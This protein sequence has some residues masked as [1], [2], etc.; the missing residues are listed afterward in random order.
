NFLEVKS[1]KLPLLE[2]QCPTEQHR[3]RYHFTPKRN[4]INDPNGM[5]YYDG[6]YHLFY[7]YHPYS[8]DRGPMHWGHATS[9]DMLRWEEQDVAL[10][11]DEVG[12]C[13]SG[14]SVIDSTNTTGFQTDPNVHPLVAIYTSAGEAGQSQSIAYSNDKGATFTKYPGN[15][16]IPNPDIQDFRDPKVSYIRGQWVMTLAVGNRIEFYG[17]PDLKTWTKLSEFG[18][19]PEEGSHC[20]SWECPDLFPLIVDVNGD[21]TSLVELWV[22]LVSIGCGGPTGG[23]GTQYFVGDFNGTTFTTLGTWDNKQ[24]LDWGPDNYAAVSFSNEPNGRTIL[25]GWM[26]NLKYGDNLPTVSWRGQ[27]TIPR[28]LDLQVLDK[29]AKKYRLTSMPVAEVETLHSPTK[30]LEIA[31][32]FTLAVNE[33]VVLTENSRLKTPGME[34]KIELEIDQNPQFSICAYNSLEEEVCF[35]Y[36]DSKWFLDR[37]KSGNTNF[38]GGFAETLRAEADREVSSQNVTIRMFW[39]VSSVEVFVDDGLTV[40]TSLFY[41][42]EPLDMIRITHG[43]P[44]GSPASLKVNSVSIWGLIC[45]FLEEDG[46]TESPTTVAP[47]E[48]TQPGTGTSTG[49]SSTTESSGSKPSVLNAVFSLFLLSTSFVTQFYC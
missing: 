23:S 18:A 26:N 28:S 45:T 29:D 12:D 10:N 25:M 32:E 43:S 49:S 36:E 46:T 21:G 16:A 42:T 22:L 27:M 24:W 20:S 17:S 39:D 11:P 48:T 41:A 38:H 13:W 15:P 34:L 8:S 4:W 2:P 33:T 14:S 1:T 3:L 19:D 6:I 44:V 7:Q 35:G 47:I 40:M 5:V 9:S 30:I 31:Q 37:S